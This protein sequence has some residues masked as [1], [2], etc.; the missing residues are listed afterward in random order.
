MRN[1]QASLRKGSKLCEQTSH[2]VAAPP[3]TARTQACLKITQA[4]LKG[5]RAHAAVR[6]RA[7]GEGTA[8]GLPQ[9]MLPVPV[10]RRVDAS[11][12]CMA[13]GRTDGAVHGRARKGRGDGVARGAQLRVHQRGRHRLGRL[14]VDDAAPVVALHRPVQRGGGAGSQRIRCLEASCRAPCQDNAE[15]AAVHDAA[16]AAPDDGYRAA[17]LASK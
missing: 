8:L 9:P 2:S 16:A 3:L 11:E 13:R 15:P 6:T 14:P 5:A 7:R 1:L 4:R 17:L 10:C 12:P